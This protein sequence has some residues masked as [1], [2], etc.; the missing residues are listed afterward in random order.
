MALAPEGLEGQNVKM[1]KA[2]S[3]PNLALL[4]P[5]LIELDSVLLLFRLFGARHMDIPRCV[6]KTLTTLLFSQ[7]C[8]PVESVVFSQHAIVHRRSVKCRREPGIGERGT[9]NGVPENGNK[10]AVCRGIQRTEAKFSRRRTRRRS[11]ATKARR[12]LAVRARR[13]SGGVRMKQADAGRNAE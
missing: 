2:K 10:P 7:R 3:V 9:G 4:S 8:R 13:G 1:G 6:P 12:G 5:V 11:S